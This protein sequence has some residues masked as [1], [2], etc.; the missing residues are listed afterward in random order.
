M[1]IVKKSRLRNIFNANV[2]SLWNIFYTF[3]AKL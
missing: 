1:K 3:V 2:A